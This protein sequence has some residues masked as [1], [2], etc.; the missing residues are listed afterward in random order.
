MKLNTGVVVRSCRKRQQKLLWHLATITENRSVFFFMYRRDRGKTISLTT[1]DFEHDL[2]EG[3]NHSVRNWHHLRASCQEWYCPGLAGL[4]RLIPQSKYLLKLKWAQNQG[5]RVVLWDVGAQECDF[6]FLL[7]K[8]GGILQPLTFRGASNTAGW[9]SPCP[10]ALDFQGCNQIIAQLW[11]S[12]TFWRHWGWRCS[13]HLA[14]LTAPHCPMSVWWNPPGS[15][16]SST[17]YL[18]LCTCNSNVETEVSSGQKCAC[19]LEYKKV[20]GGSGN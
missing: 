9:S 4:A 15:H 8:A 17:M 11:I 3:G 13:L 16:W 20:V 10:E 6:Q 12:D 14:G 1:K 19:W 18:P 5:P 2:A 7:Y